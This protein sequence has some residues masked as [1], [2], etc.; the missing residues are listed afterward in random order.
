MHRGTNSYLV[1]SGRPDTMVA[2]FIDRASSDPVRAAFVMYPMGALK[3]FSRLSWGDWITESRSACGALLSLHTARGSRVAIFADNRA[4]WPVAALGALMCGLVPVAIHPQCKPDEVAA[5]LTD[6]GASVVIVDTVARFKMLQSLQSSLSQKLTV[7]CDDLEPLRAS[8]AEGVYEWE[9]WCRAGAKALDEY[10]PMRNQLAERI[11][12]LQASDP[13]FMTYESGHA[14]M[15]THE[16][17]IAST[18]A[19]V[20]TFGLTHSDRVSSYKSLHEPF[21]MQLAVFGTICAGYTTALLE[22]ATDAFSSARQFETSVF[23]GAP[24]A[25]GRIREAFEVAHANGS[26]LRDTTCEMLGRHCR[27]ALL[28]GEVLPEQLHRD[29]RSGGVALATVYGTS[30]QIC[31]CTNGP[32][33]FEDMAIGTPVAGIE[34][35][36]GDHDELLVKRSA[37]TIAARANAAPTMT[38]AEWL[39]T[40][41]RVETLVSGSYRILGKVRDLLE[42]ENGRKFEPHSI[43]ASLSALPLVAHA[44][45]HADG[46]DSMVAI[47]SLNRSAVETWALKQGIA[48]PWEALVTLPLVYEELARGVEHINAQFPSTERI[49]AFAPTDLEF[50]VHSG[51]LNDAGEVVRG[52]VASRFRHVIAELHK[53]RS[54]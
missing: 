13:A 3:A 21:E 48:M 46:A 35:R 4:L 36:L 16:N 17:V 51:E 5:Q 34:T 32:Q 19:I 12:Q 15:M 42:F 20:S 26:Y 33:K 53:Q 44:V 6:C 7:V 29:L 41:D 38:D 49:T 52:V 28:Y 30:W 22:H 27:L 2:R 31:I 47:L 25:F 18:T 10:E 43:E 14:V 50:S 23:S 1:T 40:G 11:E 8:V 54:F 37:H 45:C 9:S 39:P 24:R